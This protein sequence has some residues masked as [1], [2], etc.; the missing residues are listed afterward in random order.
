MPQWIPIS[1]P[2]FESLLR[3]ELEECFSEERVLFERSRID[4]ER[5]PF[6]T[7]TYLESAFVVA[8]RGDEIMYY[9]DIEGGFNTS[10]VDNDG[11]ILEYW[12]NQDTLQAALH[13]WLRHDQPES[14]H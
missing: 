6:A 5:R 10:A 2:D 7:K 13:T 8:S 4:V 9:N 1:Q 14:K 3:E 11:A 12:C